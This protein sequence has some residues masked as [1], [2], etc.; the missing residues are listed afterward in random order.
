MHFL[1][2]MSMDISILPLYSVAMATHFEQWPTLIVS[3][4][5]M[6]E[7]GEK[8]EC[9]GTGGKANH[10]TS[11]TIETANHYFLL[12]SGATVAESPS[13][14]LQLEITAVLHHGLE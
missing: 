12:Q 10:Y 11:N 8:I 6:K 13:P 9:I 4:Q 3:D 14:L 5:A 1:P 2:L 7:G